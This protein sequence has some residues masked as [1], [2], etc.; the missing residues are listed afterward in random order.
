MIIA[1]RTI[2]RFFVGNH[3]KQCHSLNCKM[4]VPVKYAENMLQSLLHEVE[5]ISPVHYSQYLPQFEGS[6]GGHT[7]HILDHYCKLL[8]SLASNVLEIDYD[9][10]ERGTAVET[11]RQQA[12]DSIR[13]NINALR[14]LIP[15]VDILEHAVVTR[16]I[17]DGALRTEAQAHS[18]VER[19]LIFVGHHAVHH[20][21]M[22]KL[23]LIQ[24]GY[25][26]SRDV[27]KAPS[28]IAYERQSN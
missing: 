28:T 18:T 17:A 2:S 16:F 12:I 13:D 26:V 22:I 19:E 24:H 21:A 3:R 5:K 23:M 10:R 20:I 15:R 9:S 8:N 11:N 6:V 25:S 14:S 4:P 7:R 1:R 27:G